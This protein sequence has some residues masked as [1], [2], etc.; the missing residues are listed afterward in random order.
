MMMVFEAGM[1]SPDSTMAVE[2]RTSAWPVTNF[3][4]VASSSRS[5]IW[6]CPMITRASGTSSWMKRAIEG[7]DCTRLWTKNTWPPRSS[8]RSSA[9]LMTALLKRRTTVSTGSRSSGGV[10]I[11]DM[12][13]TPDS[14]M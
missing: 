4:I 9:S 8:S 13:R 3:T 5:F 12:S 1:S 10:S 2:T 7:S 14:D 11:T 6:P